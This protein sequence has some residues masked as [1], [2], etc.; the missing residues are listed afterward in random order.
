MSQRSLRVLIQ[1]GVGGHSEPQPERV[2]MRSPLL[3]AAAGMANDHLQISGLRRRPQS[4]NLQRFSGGGDLALK[5]MLRL[6]RAS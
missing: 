2:C 4:Q 5:T 3:P 6:L 1:A